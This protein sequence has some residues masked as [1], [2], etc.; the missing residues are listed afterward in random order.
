MNKTVIIMK[1]ELK[2]QIRGLAGWIV[3]AVVLLAAM[4]DG[5]P[6][7]S[8][9]GRLEFLSQPSYFVFRILNFDVLL[10]IFGLSFLVSSRIHGDK[11]LGMKDLFMT[12]PINKVQYAVG[13]F[14]GGILFVYFMFTFFLIA[15]VILYHLASPARAPITEYIIPLLKTLVI[16]GIPASCFIGGCAVILPALMDIRLFYLIFGV[17]FI[18]NATAVG[19]AEQMPFYLITSGDLAKLIWQHPKYPYIDMKSVGAN[20]V[21]LAGGGVLSIVILLLKR[22]FWRAE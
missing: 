19:S 20:F 21:F 4:L 6:S 7:E 9:L 2:M 8:N 13:K 16:C 14:L 18:I 17:F 1:Y 22:K 11:H 15:N 12:M 10:L 3:T 5:F